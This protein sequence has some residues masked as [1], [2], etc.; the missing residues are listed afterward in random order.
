MGVAPDLWAPR[1]LQ[2]SA[3]WLLLA[4]L[5]TLAFVGHWD[6]LAAPFTSQEVATT[7]SHTP[8]SDREH[9]Q[10]C[11]AGFEECGGGVSAFSTPASAPVHASAQVPEGRASHQVLTNELA[12]AGFESGPLT[13][14][15]RQGG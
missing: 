7:H 3:L 14:P 12:P 8:A 13:P 6:S 2:R 9:A 5:P 11:H 1:Q 4:W 15:P 10:H